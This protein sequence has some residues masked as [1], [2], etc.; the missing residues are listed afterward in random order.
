M[1]IQPLGNRITLKAPQAP[2]KIGS[3]WIPPEAQEQYTLCQAEVVARGPL[4][5][6]QRLQPGV[7]VIVKRFGGFAHDDKREIF[8]VYEDN[9]LAVVVL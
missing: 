7:Y 9:V 5:R 4:V 3:L 6:D 8:T 2:D 1:E